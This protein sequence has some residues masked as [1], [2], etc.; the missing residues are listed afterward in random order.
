MQGF[1][2]HEVNRFGTPSLITRSSNDVRQLQTALLMVLTMIVSAPLMAVGG[3]VM[4]V[5]QHPALSSLL[6]FSIPL[7]LVAVALL[8]S[9]TVPYFQKMQGQIDRVNQVLREQI[10]GLRVIRAFARDGAERERFAVANDALTDTALHTG[11]WMAT[12]IQVAVLVMQWTTVALAWFAARRIGAGTLQVGSLVAF[13]AYVAQILMSVMMAALLSATLPRALVC[14]RRVE[15]LLSTPSSVREPAASTAWAVARAVSGQNCG[16]EFR[17]VAFQYPGAATPAL[18]GINLRIAP[19]QTAAVIGATGSGR[20]TLLNLIPRLFDVT[21]GGVQVGGIDVR[22]LSLPALWGVI[23]LV[24]QQAWLFAGSIASN[25]RFGRPD[26]IDK[27]LWDAL[28]VTQAT[29]FVAALPQGLATAVAQGGGNF[30]GGQRQRLATARAGRQAAHSPVRRQLLCHRLRHR[31]AAPRRAA[32]PHARRRHA[33]RR[34]AHRLLAP[35]RLYRGAGPWRR[36]RRGHA[37]KPVG[38]LQRLP[39]DRGLSAGQRGLAVNIRG[40]PTS[41]PGAGAHRRD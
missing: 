8:M 22:E 10:T 13:L 14:A 24:P 29:D 39:R 26:A 40:A 27:E 20:S 34:P 28:D 38:R 32:Q 23:G 30:C 19:G 41:G 6:A 15:E 3:V 1:S 4:A 21:G 25:L 5:R 7:L 17:A 35:R 9:H 11:R 37:R 18:R 2:L 12:L 16:V 33:A 31:R 36:H